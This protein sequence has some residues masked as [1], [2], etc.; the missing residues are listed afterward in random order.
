ML[1]FYL[2]VVCVVVGVLVL[3]GLCVVLILVECVVE[4]VVYWVVCE[5]FVENVVDFDWLYVI[6][7]VVVGCCEGDWCVDFGVGWYG[8]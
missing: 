2:V 6:F 1:D 3:V 7:D 4:D 8:W 5:W